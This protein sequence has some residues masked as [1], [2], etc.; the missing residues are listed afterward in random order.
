MALSFKPN[1]KPD[2]YNN[3]KPIYPSHVLNPKP[4]AA[5]SSHKS[6]GV[7]RW[8]S[9][10]VPCLAVTYPL[11]DTSLHP[12]VLLYPFRCIVVANV[13]SIMSRRILL[14]AHLK[15]MPRGLS[16][17]SH[18]WALILSYSS[19]RLVCKWS[20]QELQ[21]RMFGPRVNMQRC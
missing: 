12:A 15:F 21:P 11:L 19:G 14:S 8:G 20:R 16:R 2:P 1:P 4:D 7:W 9:T 6:I 17:A 5:S 13:L 10:K 18:V 3:N